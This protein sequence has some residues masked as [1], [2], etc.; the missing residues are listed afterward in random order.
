MTKSKDFVAAEILNRLCYWTRLTA[1]REMM[2]FRFR[3]FTEQSV[4][5]SRRPVTPRLD[6]FGHVASVKSD[7]FERQSTIRLTA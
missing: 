3:S 5:R 4:P 6:P 7:V 2:R 1:I